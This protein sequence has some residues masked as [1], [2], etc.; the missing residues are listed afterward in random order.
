[1][2]SFVATLLLVLCSMLV[3]V[4]ANNKKKG[5]GKV[6]E[7]AYKLDSNEKNQCKMTESDLER[8]WQNYFVAMNSK[9]VRRAGGKKK[10]CGQCVKV[11]GAASG[12]TR[13]FK[14]NA[15]YAKIVD[16]CS[17]KDCAEGQLDFSKKA[18][19][20]ITSFAWDK[21]EIQWK[22]TDCP[23]ISNFRS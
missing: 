14:N 4:T 1:M 10:V 20:D 15:V 8:K 9:D 12:N 22:I 21:K 19:K 6:G 16:V 2:R 13:S 7:K 17:S 18:L 3:L 5:T 11:K 23:K